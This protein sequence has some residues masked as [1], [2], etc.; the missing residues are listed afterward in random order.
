MREGIIGTMSPHSASPPDASLLR[1]EPVWLRYR[2]PCGVEFSLDPAVGG[3]CVECHREIDSQAI[4]LANSA[5]ISLPSLDDEQPCFDFASSNLDLAAGTMLGHFRLES[6]IGKGGMGAVYL[7]FDTSLERRVAVKVVRSG[8]MA[9]EAQVASMLREAVAQA[10][11]NHP[12]VVAIYYVGRHKTEP[13]LAME[14]VEGGTVADRVSGGSLPYGEAIQLALEV[15]EALE[16]ASHFGI[17]HADIKPSNLLISR[18][19]QLKL[20]DFGL[21]RM[22]N[23][24]TNRPTAGTPAYLAPELVAGKPLSIQS[25]M[26]ALG[27]TLYQMVFGVLPFRL[28]GESLREQVQSLMTAELEFPQPWPANIPRGFTDLIARL[29]AKKP[30]ARFSDYAQLKTALIGVRPT[31][32]TLAGIAP[33]AMAYVIDQSVLLLAFVPF[34][35]LILLLETQHVFYQTLIPVVA[36]GSLVVPA[37]Y[38]YLMRRRVPSLGR[39]LFQ[40]RISEENGLPPG[41]EQLLTREFLRNLFAWMLPLGAYFS[42]Y[43]PPALL[44]S[45]RIFALFLLAELICLLSTRHR[46]TLHDWLCRSRVVLKVDSHQAA[47]FL[48]QP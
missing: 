4:Q 15:V 47:H 42:L 41:R 43:Y 21:A 19:P 18:H 44:L 46:R 30:E 31:T 20:S 32:T 48:H 28:S 23:E 9:S 6:L 34:A 17:V 25:D 24:G 22:V 33:R 40:L 36:L 16:H 14:Y 45:M 13:F 5:T 26:Y 11:L 7:A 8:E 35:S 2:C 39:Y 3:S 27:V 1:P 12:N 29:L 38:L 10:R 37:F